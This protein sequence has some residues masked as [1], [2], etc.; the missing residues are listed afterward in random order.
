MAKTIIIHPAIAP[1]RIDFFNSL[2]NFFATS[3]Y[4]EHKDVLEQKFDKKFIDDQLTFTPL[5]LRPGLFGIKNL[6]LEVLSILYREKPDIVLCSEYNIIGFLIVLYKLLFNWK[7][8]VFSICDDSYTMAV[9][10]RGVRKW[11]RYVLLHVFQGVFLSDRKALIWYEKTFTDK[12]RFF[13]FPIIQEENRF[14][15]NLD[16]A[17]ALS[18]KWIEKYALQNKKVVLYVGRLVAVKN[19]ELLIQSFSQVHNK[20]LDTHLVLVGDGEEQES[21]LKLASELH[22]SD[23]VLFAGKKEGL[24]LYAWYNIGQLFV[25][26]STYEP[27]G[28]VTNEALL[29]GCYVLCSNVAGS[30]CLITE[31]DNGALFNPYDLQELVGKMNLYI[32]RLSVT[33]SK[34]NKMQLSYEKKIAELKTFIEG[35]KE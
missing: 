32:E 19:V 18:K 34:N 1:Y 17:K 30:S 21:L 35:E 11:M 22:I 33:N 15:T 14:L 23:H 5:Y 9:G 29:A 26:P 20:H 3:I 28:T 6:R 31:G 7:L 12:C 16:S 4:I 27:F 2:H 24:E 8:S 10:C 25:L 13:F